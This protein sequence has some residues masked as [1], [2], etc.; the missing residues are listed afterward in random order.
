[1][2]K[3]RMRAK[4]PQLEEALYGYFGAHHAFVARQIIDHID[5]LD[6]AIGALTQPNF[7]NSSAFSLV[8]GLGLE[9]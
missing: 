6:S 4:I 3:S 8:E 1:M 5:Y 7:R 9:Q 2:A